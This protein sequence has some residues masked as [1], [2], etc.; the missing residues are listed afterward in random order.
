MNQSR[1]VG[2]AHKSIIGSIK[3]ILASEE[4][5][6]SPPILQGRGYANEYFLKGSRSIKML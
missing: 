3:L 6:V 4:V 2:I 5:E 1:R